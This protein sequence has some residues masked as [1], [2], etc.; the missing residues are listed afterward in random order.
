[1][2]NN[3]TLLIC[4]ITI[5]AL[6]IGAIVIVP[7]LTKKPSDDIEPSNLDISGYDLNKFIDANED[8]GGIADHVKG[9][10]IESAKVVLFEYADYQCSGCATVN[11]WI[12]ELLAEYG[13]EVAIVYRDLPL[14]SIHPNAIAAASAVEA[15][16]L[17]GYWEEY[18]DLVF[19]NQAEWFYSTGSKR[20]EYFAN[21]FNTV[22]G[23]KGDVNKFKADM[24]GEAVKAK[25]NFDRAIAESLGIVATPTIFDANGKEIDWASA[26][27]TKTGVIN[28]F[29]NY[30]N[31]ALG[32]EETPVETTEE[33]YDYYY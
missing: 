22:S 1:M 18:G 8:N 31:E 6:F 4:I 24:A 28:F 9:A 3:R 15:A 11:P 26:D 12:K 27:S 33:T 17:Q 13:D 19:A 14:T 7:Q 30:F 20:T 21:Y 10:D 29:R 32:R 25:V 2:K 23:G 5:V 16:G